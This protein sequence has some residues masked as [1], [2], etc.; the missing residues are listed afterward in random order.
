MKAQLPY[1]RIDHLILGTHDGSTD[2]VAA[3]AHRHDSDRFDTAAFIV[4]ACNSHDDLVAALETIMRAHESG[5]NGAFIGEAV[6]C[7]HY[8]DMAR[9]ALARAK[10]E[11]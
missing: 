5:N 10:G 2:H 1:Y 6:L 4:R 11:A 3:V 9:A 8:A 7:D